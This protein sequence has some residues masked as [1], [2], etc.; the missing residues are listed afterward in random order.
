MRIGNI[1]GKT[2]KTRIRESAKA[3]LS[4]VPRIPREVVLA[5]RKARRQHRQELETRNWGNHRGCGFNHRCPTTANLD[6]WTKP[7][8]TADR[9]IERWTDPP[10]WIVD[11]QI[12]ETRSCLN[13]GPVKANECAAIPN[14][15]RRKNLER[16]YR[17]MSW[18]DMVQHGMMVEK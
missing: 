6:N 14:G 8:G 1:I 4:Q 18:N 5:R 3:N 13:V 7:R 12:G 11:P 16:R 9:A 17:G 10:E 2:M 15:T